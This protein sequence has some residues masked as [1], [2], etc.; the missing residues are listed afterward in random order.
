M[1]RI[2]NIAVCLALLYVALAHPDLLVYTLG[3]F[4]GGVALTASLPWFV[5]WGQRLEKEAKTVASSRRE[6]R[7]DEVRATI[8]A[9]E[10]GRQEVVAIFDRIGVMVPAEVRK[11]WSEAT[12]AIDI[13]NVLNVLAQAR[14]EFVREQESRAAL[15]EIASRIGDRRLN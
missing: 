10:T 1:I 3:G 6:V 12:N 13:Q 14:C 9:L 15:R 11:P 4:A 8:A 7:S 5:R 2:I